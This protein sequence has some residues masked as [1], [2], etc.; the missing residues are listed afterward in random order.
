MSGATCTR[1]YSVRPVVLNKREEK[2]E[3]S[4]WWVGFG[5]YRSEHAR[6]VQ[7]AFMAASADNVKKYKL[8]EGQFAH[9]MIQNQR[10]II[11]AMAI[12]QDGVVATGADNG[13]LWCARPSIFLRLCCVRLVSVTSFTNGLL[14][15][16]ARLGPNAASTCHA[17]R[18]GIRRNVLR[19]L[20]C[21]G[22]GGIR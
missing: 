18:P 15:M 16:A 7:W 12:N 1:S 3:K 2:K 5:S 17:S 8:P 21:G 4:K 10:A 9:N 13:S 20:F 11:N 14:H 6:M 22:W 19:A